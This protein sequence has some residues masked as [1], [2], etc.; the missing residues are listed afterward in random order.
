MST[1]TA[2]PE[3]YEL[4]GDEALATLRTT[5]LRHLAVDAVRRFRAADGTSHARSLAFQI[6]LTLLPFVIAFVGLAATL[7]GQTLTRGIQQWVEQVAPGPAGQVIT[8]AFT[9]GERAA[10]GGRVAL[11]AGLIATIASATV[12]MGQVERSANR[13]YGVEAD[14]PTLRKYLNGLV[15]AC[16]AGVLVVASLVLLVG[17]ESLVT[18]VL[19]GNGAMLLLWNAGR[20]VLGVAAAVGG[21][22]LL[23]QRAPRRRQ[24][25]VSWLA[26]G[27]GLA[28][29][30]WLGFTALLAQYLS[31]ST[32]SFG[33]TYGPLA[34]VIGVLL[35]AFATSFALL[36]GLAFAAQLEAVRAGVPGPSTAERVN[37]P[38]GRRDA[39]PA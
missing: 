30:L 33:Q 15:L 18:A 23:F 31:A 6:V 38:P 10:A 1:A 28:V 19:P 8:Q 5:G 17:G 12:A 37:Q 2:V 14:R 35:W 24:P 9:Q 34:G 36:L 27:S 29:V 26:F 7:H 4:E 21:F 13:I 20:W 11:T 16:S 25:Q 3:T 22:A 32:A 39:R